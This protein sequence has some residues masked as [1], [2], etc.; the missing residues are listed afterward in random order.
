MEPEVYLNAMV[1]EGLDEHV[2]LHAE[3]NPPSPKCWLVDSGCSNHFSPNQSNFTLYELYDSPRKICLG[4][5]SITPSLGEG[6]MSLPCIMNRKTVT[7][8]VHNVQYVPGLTYGLLSTSVLN[9]HGL[10]VTMGNKKCTIV[11]PDGTV[12]AEALRVTGKLYF[13]NM[14][15]SQGSPV[16]SIIPVLPPTALVVTLSFDLIHKHLVH[17]GKEAL[18]LMI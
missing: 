18:Q 1:A 10:L 7:Q 2:A 12:I 9:D 6:T 13:L 5:L 4:N 14:N 17:P 11:H 16:T 8:H 3:G 15:I